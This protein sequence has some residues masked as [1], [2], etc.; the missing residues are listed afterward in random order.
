MFNQLF[1]NVT[2]IDFNPIYCS[3]DEPK[4]SI[5][6]SPAEVKQNLLKSTIHGSVDFS[7]VT[8]LS[9]NQIIPKVT[10][11]VHQLISK[12]NYFS[13]QSGQSVHYLI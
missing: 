6:I 5:R 8:Y 11:S 2:I 4:G 3:Y 13:R 12:V 1:S 7:G 9:R 10:N